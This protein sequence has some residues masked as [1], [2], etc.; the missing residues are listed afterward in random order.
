VS[1][2]GSQ[3]SNP[4]FNW[5]DKAGFVILLRGVSRLITTPDLPTCPFHFDL[6]IC[7]RRKKKKQD[8]NIKAA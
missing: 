7:K 2:I 8:V 4:P 1:W 3:N 5:T 6:P